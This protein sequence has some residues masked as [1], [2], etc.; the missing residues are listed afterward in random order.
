MP[1]DYLPPLD[2]LVRLGE[3]EC[4]HTCW[5]DYPGRFGLGQEHVPELVRM[6]RDPEWAEADGDSPMVYASVHAWRA[7]GQLRAEAAIPALLDLI[8]EADEDDD[9]VTE[10]LST[11]FEHIGRAAFDPL[12]A[13]FR[14]RSAGEK[15]RVRA[16]SAFTDVVRAA[17]DLR[18]EAVRVLTRALDA[19]TPESASLHVYLISD[20][21]QLQAL[22]SLPSMRRAFQEDRVDTD[23]MDW[24]E[25]E[26]T[27][28]FKK[29]RSMPLA[30]FRRSPPPAP[31]PLRHEAAPWDDWAPP[32]P[33]PSAPARRADR[34]R[35]KARKKM[36]KNSRKQ[37]R[38][39]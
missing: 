22:E 29:Q 25:V 21:L 8:R 1:N 13:L 15:A 11:V 4:G 12:V 33:P 31:A 27:L 30:L 37:N 6:L 38:R 9:W 14:D 23:L 3:P 24:E 18:G 2:Q 7:L 17:P 32:P 16:A 36:A 10:D 34:E 5:M 39:K 26:V 19:Y 20:L 28:G 35:E